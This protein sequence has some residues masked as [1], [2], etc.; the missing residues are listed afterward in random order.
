MERSMQI[1]GNN[2]IQ[3]NGNLSLNVSGD[4]PVSKKTLKKLIRKELENILLKKIKTKKVTYLKNLKAPESLFIEPG[5]VT[6]LIDNL[7]PRI[8]KN[9]ILYM[10]AYTD[11]LIAMQNE[12]QFLKKIA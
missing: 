8:Q 4:L 10:K 2:N 6:N 3:V 1:D 11:Q 12:Q 7:E 9:D 5:S